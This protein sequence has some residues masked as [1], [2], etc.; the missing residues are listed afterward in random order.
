MPPSARQSKYWV[1]TINNYTAGDITTVKTWDT[2]YFVMGK[3]VGESGTPH[4]QGYVE[5]RSK[6]RFSYMKDS[7]HATAR[8]AARNGTAQQAADYCKK[9]GDFEEGGDISASNQ[10]HR[11]DLEEAAEALRTRQL[12][13][14]AESFPTVYIKFHRGLQMYKNVLQSKEAK[15]APKVYVF[16]GPTGTGKSFKVREMSPDCFF[17]S[18]AK[19]Y[20]GYDGTS[21]I[22]FDDF[23]GQ[24]TINNFL[25]LIDRYE[26]AVETKGGTLHF[27]PKRI[28]ITSHFDPET[29]YEAIGGNSRW[30]EI[31]RRCTGIHE[32]KWKHVNNAR[33]TEV[34]GNTRPPLPILEPIFIGANI[35]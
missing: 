9:D 23:S 22:C 5:M 25:R 28:F 20:D 26:V 4:I 29:W 27:K 19:W 15:A 1:F 31:E 13:D 14:V 6:K 32:F 30:P 10:G 11:T 21:D 35:L 34:G 17:T 18:N 33:V 12:S 24:I 16:W 7:C 3:E 2:T 8:W